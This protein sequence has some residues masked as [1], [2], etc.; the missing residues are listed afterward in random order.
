MAYNKVVFGSTTLVDLTSDTVTADVLM[1]GYT[2]HD[3]SGNLIVGTAKGGGMSAKKFT[4][5]TVPST[6][7]TDN[8]DNAMLYKAAI[9]LDEVESTDYP[10]VIFDLDD[11]ES[12]GFSTVC[13][14]GDGTVTIYT[15]YKPA[16]DIVIPSIVCI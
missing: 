13:T 5:I 14:A 7:W 6:A 12:Y 10:Q 16:D 2:A 1:E 4:D 11:I 8:E 3:C 9:S 15:D